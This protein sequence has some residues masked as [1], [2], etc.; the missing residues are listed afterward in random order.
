ML[1]LPYDVLLRIDACEDI[2]TIARFS[3][4]FSLVHFLRAN[5]HM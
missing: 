1:E 5:N 3:M 4:T 2:L